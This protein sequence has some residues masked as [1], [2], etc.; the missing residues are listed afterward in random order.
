MPRLQLAAISGLN[1]SLKWIKSIGID[2]V[3]NEEQSNYKRLLEMLGNYENIS[4]IPTGYAETIGVASCVFNGY[5]SD[6]IGKILSEK[7]VAVRTGLHC[8][9][10]AH[11][12]LGTFP[13]G[14]VRFS[15]SYFNTDEDFEVLKEALDYIAQNS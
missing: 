12:Y 7:D 13:S 5:C 9:P 4:V 6:N 15:V 3:Y 14:T 8:A 10:V 11:K 1:V 2:Q